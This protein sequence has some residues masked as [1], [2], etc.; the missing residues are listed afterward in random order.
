MPSTTLMRSLINRSTG[1][2]S[3]ACSHCC[4]TSD[5]KSMIV[6]GL[7]SSNA[8]CSDVPYMAIADA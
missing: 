2:Q 4:T 8:S 5:G 6:A 3:A 7:S 1:M